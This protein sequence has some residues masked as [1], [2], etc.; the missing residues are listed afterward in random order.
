V[1]RCPKGC[2]GSLSV[3]LDEA[4]GIAP[5]QNSSDEL[6]RLGCLFSLFVPYELAA[7]LLGQFSGLPVS[8]SSLWNWVERRGQQALDELSAQLAQ[9]RSGEPVVPEALSETLAALT[10]AVS[11]DG[12][13][14][15][16]RSQ[17]KCAKGKIIWREV[18]V[19]LFARLGERLNRA[20]EAVVKL[21]H[22][23][24]VAVLGDLERFIPQVRLE[25]TKQSFETAPKVVWLSDGGRG[26]WRVYHQCFAHCAVAVLDFYHAAGHLWRV[27]T[28][29]FD[30]QSDQLSWFKRWR[31]ALRH[32]QHRTVLAM[33]TSLV[34]T[35]LLSG[36]ALHTLSQVQAY[37]QRHHAHIRYQ[38]FYQQHMP[39]GSGMVESACKWLVQQRFKGVGMHW[40]ESGLNHLLI[41]RVA[42]ANQRFDALFPAVPKSSINHPSLNT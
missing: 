1:G 41:L 7:W 36:S 42:W 24:L 18:K 10:L 40:S 27:A 34:N 14:V 35:D 38:H 15:A 25:A 32:G 17:P 31:H 33:L 21:K 2:E 30:C 4:L 37:F 29:L 9:Q 12:V 22:R 28:V 8:A 6:V 11:A 5:H 19:A 13:M 16:L 39:L 20:G 23:R 3:P 26:F